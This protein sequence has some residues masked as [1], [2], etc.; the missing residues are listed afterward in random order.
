M[1]HGIDVF[2]PREPDHFR[3]HGACFVKLWDA[4]NGPMEVACADGKEHHER[5]IALMMGFAEAILGAGTIVGVC[6]LGR[7]HD[8]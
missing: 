7:F 4:L 5:F 2:V 8:M 1:Q 6:P 3:D